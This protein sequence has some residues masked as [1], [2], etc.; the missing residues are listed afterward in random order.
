MPVLNKKRKTSSKC[1]VP[2]SV[3]GKNQ[4]IRKY[5][6]KMLINAS[7]SK[8]NLSLKD[9]LCGVYFGYIAELIMSGHIENSYITESKGQIEVRWIIDGKTYVETVKY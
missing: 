3:M 2:Q 4:M 9:Y 5:L 6:W 7:I 8:K 1:Y